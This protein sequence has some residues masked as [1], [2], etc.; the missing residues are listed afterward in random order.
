MFAPFTVDSDTF[1]PE[2]PRPWSEGRYQTRGSRRMF[3]VHPDGERVALAPAPRTPGRSNPD[4]VV[5]VFNFFDEL[6]GLTSATSR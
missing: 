2:A 6:R 1:H 3:D 4:S 5:F